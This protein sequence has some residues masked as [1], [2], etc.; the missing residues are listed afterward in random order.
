MVK[1][2]TE[3]KVKENLLLTE[4]IRKT[5]LVTQRQKNI[6]KILFIIVI[7]ATFASILL[8]YFTHRIKKINTKLQKSTED[9]QR[10][11]IDLNLSKAQIESV[12]EF[13]TQFIANMSHEI[14]TPLNI[15]IGFNSMLKKSLT[16][17]KL[18]TFIDAIDVSSNNLLQLLNDILDLSKMEAGKMQLAPES[19]NLANLLEDIRKLFV[20][21]AEEKGL[22]LSI[23]I[24]P[25]VPRGLVLDE[26]RLRQVLLNLI[27]NAIK[28]TDSGFVKLRVFV[29]AGN[30]RN[31]SSIDA[32]D[33]IFEIED[34]G[35]GISEKDQTEIFESFKQI[36]TH[37]LKRLGGTGLGLPIS[38]RLTELIGGKI[39]VSSKL[40]KGSKFSVI[41]K[42]IQVVAIEGPEKR[43]P[44]NLND[45]TDIE[46]GEGTLIIA[47]DEDL[48]RS[49]IKACFENTKVIVLEAQNGDEAIELTRKHNPSVVLMDLK[50]PIKDG[51]EAAAEIKNDE[52]TQ[53]VPILAFTASHLFGTSDSP[54]RQLFAGFIS[55]P[56]FLTELYEEVARFIPHTRKSSD[57]NLINSEN[58]FEKLIK[59]DKNSISRETFESLQN[60]FITEWDQI[61]QTNS[62]NKILEFSNNL[63]SFANQNNL[64]ALSFYANE[65]I[66]S[67]TSF[68]IDRVMNQIRKFP[69]IIQI[70]KPTF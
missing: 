7:F 21:R 55:K 44:G 42:N 19:I 27:G 68:D 36:K 12:L 20:L 66:T 58:E 29:D 26:V 24:E 31:I 15:I 49:L 33:L 11:N 16:D 46:F 65:I 53:T 69:E 17:P 39:E 56:V 25:T 52:K 43:K 50:M 6:S 37:S 22:D 3:K 47:D 13:K 1:P 35:I 62:M 60:H 5:E 14:R 70:L 61:N 54:D 28:F 64:K 38:K 30:S 41:L 59:I 18:H 51:F 2:E 34:S 57:Y 23:E 40:G 32:T 9:L 8:I 67:S 63:K 48:N 45:F 4:Q 10:L